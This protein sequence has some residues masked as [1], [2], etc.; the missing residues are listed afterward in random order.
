MR[1]LLFVPGDSARKLEK[2][3][4]SQADALLI[5]LE[6]SVSLKAKD[7]ARS[8]TAEFLQGNV[9]GSGRPRLYVRINGLSTGLAEADLDYVMPAAPDGVVLPKADGGADVAALAALLSR[10]EAGGTRAANRILAIA[11]ENAA[12][13][14]AHASRSRSG[15]LR[16][17]TALL[18]P[19]GSC[20][21]CHRAFA[22]RTA[23]MIRV[24]AY[25]PM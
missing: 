16:V 13:V 18:P 21:W 2:A 4:A 11:T 20:N 22:R 19:Q 14:F 3:L 1:S 15:A 9:A 12:G 17:G 8:I 5:D 10:H 23:L 24:L 6:D 7:E 25:N